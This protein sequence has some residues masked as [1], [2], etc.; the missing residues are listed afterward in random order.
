MSPNTEDREYRRFPFLAIIV[1]LVCVIVW[2]L[3]GKFWMGVRDQYEAYQQN[4]AGLAALSDVYCPGIKVD[5][6]DLG[7]KTRQE[8]SLLL[9]QQ[10]T[11]FTDDFVLTIEASGKQW[12]ITPKEIPVLFDAEE[13]LDEAWLIGHVGSQEQRAAEIQDAANGVYSFTTGY[14]LDRSA[15]DDLIAI[16]GKAVDQPAV[17]AGLDA[18]DMQTKTFSYRKESAGTELDREDLKKCI[19][20]ALDSGKLNKTIHAKMASVQPTVRVSDLEGKF[21]MISA[22]TT[23]TTNDRDR[24]TNIEISSAALNG[25]VVQPGETL[26]FNGCTGKRTG[27]KG[28]REAGTIAGGILVDDTGGGV[29]QTSSTLF[30]A[31]VRADLEREALCPQLAFPLCSE[32]RRCDGQLAF[33]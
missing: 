4:A 14:E 28:Y 12:R 2:L 8:A 9:S 23:E 18:F 25:K 5:G 16:I 17:N 24:N 20:D 21:G 15:V 30:N 32:G 22:F 11:A 6:I 13:I 7:G 27:E 19:T 31:V 29:C 33:P 10:Q 26:S 1:I 3:G